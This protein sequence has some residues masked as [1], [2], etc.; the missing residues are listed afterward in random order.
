MKFSKRKESTHIVSDDKKNYG[1]E[2]N[3][4]MYVLIVL[5]PGYYVQL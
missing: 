3:V 1:L 2:V 4:L 5:I